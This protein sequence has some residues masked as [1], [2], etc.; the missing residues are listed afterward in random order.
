LQFYLV[1]VGP[2]FPKNPLEVE[3]EVVPILNVDKK[4]EGF[5]DQVTPG[6]A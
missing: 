2:R 5:I 3:A 4:S 6:Y 1:V